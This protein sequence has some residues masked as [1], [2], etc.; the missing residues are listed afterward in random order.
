MPD[1]Q[2]GKKMSHDKIDDKIDDNFT[3]YETVPI[4]LTVA[5]DCSNAI[6]KEV[7]N[8]IDPEK[9]EVLDFACG[10]GMYV[11]LHVTI[12]LFLIL[13]KYFH[14]IGLISRALSPYVKSIVGVDI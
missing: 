3:E 9:T 13:T 6:I 11:T 8:E 5:K 14:K 2:F 12:H 7:E 1:I 10:T 4:R